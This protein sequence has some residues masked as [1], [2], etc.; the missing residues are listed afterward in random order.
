MSAPEQPLTVVTCKW[1][2]GFTAEHVNVAARMVARHYQHPHRFVCLTDDAGGLD[3]GID[4]V[5]IW[6]DHAAMP[7]PHGPAYPSC[8]RRLKL[9]APEM[10]ELLGPRF[11]SIDLDVVV[12]GDLTP[13]WHRDEDFVIMGALG[14]P[15]THYNGSMMLMTAGARAQ[16]WTD[17]DPVRSPLAALRNR[18]FGSDQGW[19]SHRL[20]RGE[21]TWG[22]RDGI[23]SYRYGTPP[24]RERLPDDARLVFF[25]GKRLA[26]W[27]EEPQ[28]RDWVREHWQ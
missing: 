21:A 15:T 25:N 1:G 6:D 11:V 2:T 18:Q 16:V 10:A 17:F 13:I 4:A 26:P 24:A 5:P 7:S 20:G 22:V 8:Y 9:F 19:I 3:I 14:S 27:A 23:Y 12:T 28:S